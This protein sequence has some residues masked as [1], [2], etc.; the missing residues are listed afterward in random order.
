[1]SRPQSPPAELGDVDFDFGNNVELTGLQKDFV[2]FHLANPEVYKELVVLARK[3][4]KTGKEKCGIGMLFEVA[5]WHFWLTTS[6]TR[7]FKMNNSLRSRYARLIME[8]EADLRGFFS[9]RELRS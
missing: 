1:M 4:K 3:A 9:L 2:H 6:T 5:R 8:Q 7:T